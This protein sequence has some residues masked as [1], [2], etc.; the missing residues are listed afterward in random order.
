MNKIFLSIS[1]LITI[2]GTAQKKSKNKIAEVKDTGTVICLSWPMITHLVFNNPIEYQSLGA[3]VSDAESRIAKEDNRVLEIQ[4]ST[5]QKPTFSR[6]NLVVKTNGKFYNYIVK[7]STSCSNPFMYVN[8]DNA[9][10]NTVDNSNASKTSNIKET[11]TTTTGGNSY[12][13]NQT[14]PQKIKF[15]YYDSTCK[16]LTRMIAND[17]AYK[18]SNKAGKVKF[19]TSKCYVKDDMLYFF[20]N[21]ANTS[22]L[23]YDISSFNFYIN[24]RKKGK[25]NAT[26]ANELIPVFVS[27]N[28]MLV[29]GFNTELS[30]VFVLNKF[31]F[32]GN[33]KKLLIECWEKNGDR[34]LKCA[35]SQDDIIDAKPF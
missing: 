35:L 4:L 3:D 2:A 16:I 6:T 23:G 28:A 24:T 32:D 27:N 7:Y 12:S 14:K 5:N 21:V 18:L 8:E 11:N 20:I 30:K 33:N 15:K 1:L 9:I 19:S 17:K 10:N 31:T 34:N 29:K 26:Q 13:Q 25:G 22:S